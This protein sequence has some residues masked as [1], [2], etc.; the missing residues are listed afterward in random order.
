[1]DARKY[2]REQI[3]RL[4]NIFIER[5]REEAYRILDDQIF[6]CLD[7]HEY[8][9]RALIEKAMESTNTFHCRGGRGLRFR[10]M[11][12]KGRK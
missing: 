2:H 7:D 8:V 10:K 6:D 12:A 4:L 3:D 9:A 1:M 5:T 11:L